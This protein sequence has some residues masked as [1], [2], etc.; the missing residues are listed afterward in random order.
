[1][2]AV[3][4]Y[5]AGSAGVI[6]LLS[7]E[8]PVP[9]SGRAHVQMTMPVEFPDT[10]KPA[11]WRRYTVSRRLRLALQS[12]PDCLL[13]SQTPSQAQEK[14]HESPSVLVVCE[15]LA[16]LSGLGCFVCPFGCRLGCFPID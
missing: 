9:L 7:S 13:A 3:S 11:A 8:Y 4:N 10:L 1:M 12:W 14:L 6:V 5:A 2:G 16:R 15:S